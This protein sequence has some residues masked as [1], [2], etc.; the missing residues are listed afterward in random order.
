MPQGDTQQQAREIL[1]RLLVWRKARISQATW[2]YLESRD[3]QRIFGITET[4]LHK[5]LAGKKFPAPSC[6]PTRQALVWSFTSVS[7]WL[8]ARAQQAKPCI[9][10]EG[11][12]RTYSL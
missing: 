7:D 11:S 6:N 4:T 8:R 5:R 10:H 9:R 12:E 1:A 3:L 2:T